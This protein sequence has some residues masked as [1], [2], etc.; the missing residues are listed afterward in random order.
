MAKKKSVFNVNEDFKGKWRNQHTF[1][2]SNYNFRHNKVTTK[3]EYQE[4]KRGKVVS[5]YEPFD[6]R[7]RNLILKR[8]SNED[9]DLPVVKF[10]QFVENDDI[11]IPYNIIEEYI[12][13]LPEWSGETD[14]IAEL[15]ATIETD[16]DEFFYD[17]LKRFLVGV[18]D[19]LLNH[20]SNDICLILQGGQGLG[21]TKWMRR[22]IPNH[23]LEDFYHES[24]IDTKNK[25]HD[26][27]LST[28]WFIMLD[29]LEVLQKSELNALKAFIT[30]TQVNHRKV[31]KEYDLKFP[32]RASFLGGVNDDEFMTDTTGNRRWLAFAAKKID[33]E[34]NVNIG[35]VYA[36]ALYLLQSGT[37]RH[38]FN[39]TEIN[40]INKRNE[41]FSIKSKEEEMFL[42]NFELLQYGQS[43]GEWLSST[44]IIEKLVCFY[45]R[46]ATNLS[47][48]KLGAIISKTIRVKGDDY[49]KSK[50]KRADANKYYVKYVG[51]TELRND[52]STHE[53]PA[54]LNVVNGIK[55]D[56]LPF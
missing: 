24:P 47:N 36:Q 43:G 29:E 23:L 11:S 31:F 38:W 20:K 55:E 12:Y 21:K 42:Q 40:E 37:F 44:D 9:L 14:H 53:K 30:K 18:V 46:T 52:G 54:P 6:D 35:N 25:E 19:C 28:K 48:R 10:R 2:C 50:E 34:H 26:E 16:D 8:M 3:L 5:E 7:V 17:V 39:R 22:L 56:D 32:R 13:G 4:I 33:Y 49:Y 45:P 15:A 51:P 41:M 27:L 1:I